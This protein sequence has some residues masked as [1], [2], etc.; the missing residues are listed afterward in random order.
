MVDGADV[1]ELVDDIANR[2]LLMSVRVAGND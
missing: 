1:P 2:T